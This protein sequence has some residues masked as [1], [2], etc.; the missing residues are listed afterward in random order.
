L[1]KLRPHLLAVGALVAILLTGVPAVLKNS[2]V[3][4][5]FSAFP[6]QASGDVV[7]IA[8]DSPSIE[9]VGVWPWPRRLHAQ[10]IGKLVSAR[11]SDIAF[12]VDFSTPSTPEFDRALTDALQS[13]GGSVI[14]PSFKQIIGGNNEKEIHLNRPMLNFAKHAWPA[15]VNISTEPDGVVRRYP[16][17][18]TFDGSFLPSMGAVLAGRY[19]PSQAPLWIDF[20]IQPSSVPVVSF[21]DV[22]A[23][24]A[25]TLARLKKKK[26][27]IGGTALELGDRF[28]IPNNQIISGAVIQALAAESI[29]QDRVLRPTS[30]LANL[31]GPVLVAIIML[32]L[33]NRTSAL[34]RVCILVTTSVAVELGGMFLQAHMAIMADTS[35]LHVTVLAY[36]ITIALDEID[37]RDLL[38][39]IA[40]RRFQR[41]AMSLGDG[42][43][44]ADTNG[45]I[46]VWNPTASAIFGY[47]SDE[48]LGRPLGKICSATDDPSTFDSFSILDLP[49]DLLQAP[50][51]KLVEIFGRRKNG[52]F[53]PLEACFSRWQ[54][55][56]GYNYGAIFRDISVRQ[57]E[58]A[59]I[60]YLAEYDALTGLANRNSLTAHLRDGIAKA[61]SDA[62]EIAL[63]V[64][65]LDKFQFIIDMLGLT[66]GEQVICA[67]AERLTTF[68]DSA[69]LVARLDGDE[70]CIVVEGDYAAANA[71]KLADRICQSFSESPLS[72]SGRQQPVTVSIGVAV[73]PKDCRT[74]D[75][76]LGNSH[77]A[78]YR[79][80]ASKRGRHV[81]FERSIRIELEARARL[82]AELTRALERNEFE[83]YYQPK[84][85]LEDDKIIGAEA[86]V[87]WRHPYRGLL[88]PG[89]F[90]HVVKTSPLS[91][92]VSLWVLRTACKQAHLWQKEGLDLSMAVNL[93]PSQLR[94]TDIVTT[95]A[96]V[97]RE[98]GCPPGRL[99][100]EVTEDILVDD[101][102]AVD[103]F[104]KLKNL[105]VRILLDDFGTGYASLSYLKKFPIN[106]LKIDKSFVCQ[107]RVEIDDAAI[108]SSTIGLSTLLGLEV[109]AEGIEDRGT[110][111][112]LA[113]M[114]CK[115]GQ[116]YFF[117]RPMPAAEFERRFVAGAD[118]I[119]PALNK[120][121]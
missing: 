116:G 103:I 53:F 70:F 111:N 85:S 59:K 23:A 120:A 50:G 45:L 75:E 25:L 99:E 83:L 113:R 26:V 47:S 11:T 32:L 80:K 51:G 64:I 18:E 91:D 69:S 108:V 6:R 93:A 97:L 15:V 112:L 109:I 58:A 20:S 33:W 68:F 14:L 52:E 106:G 57:R 73:Y 100:L 34:V 105:G 94:S 102:K 54:A 96:D 39:I 82:E 76:L 8:I 77:L 67:V 61:K 38:S 86:L 60:R 79:A 28:S 13:A 95:I 36:L 9:A 46:T 121:G 65:G 42:L 40:E 89:E 7:V 63:L 12:D 87:R 101:E 72:V 110:A 49:P 92:P 19:E 41:I 30:Q 24:D 31:L 44:C 48:M 107:L 62:V 17:G 1:K 21:K 78:L 4:L 71:E 66:Y 55:R 43:V 98:T 119:T 117:G 3:D 56:D 2:L 10:L 37:I 118:S 16:Y 27:I 115:Q 88:V 84:V 35:L 29:L 114:G 90:M 81:V 5:R 22:L 104:H 74:A